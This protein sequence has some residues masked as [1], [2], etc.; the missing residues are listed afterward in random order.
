MPI[1]RPAK[2]AMKNDVKPARSAAA[3]AGTTWNASVC[4]SSAMS[5]ATSTPSARDDA[6]EH[7][8]HDRQ[9]ARRQAGEHR[10]DLVLRR[11]RRQSEGVHR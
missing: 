1:A 2:H 10:R 9:A 11:P 7:G 4:A 6:R 3:R 8:V 5:G